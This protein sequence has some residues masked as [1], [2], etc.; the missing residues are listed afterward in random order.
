[1]PCL[2]K[3]L[4]VATAG[5]LLATL[6]AP[7]TAAP[8]RS[9]MAVYFERLR[10]M[11]PEAEVTGRFNDW[12]SVSMYRSHAGLHLGYDI[13]L[14]AGRAVPA[15]WPGR[16]NRIIP[17]TSTEYGVEVQ[18]TNGY[19]VTY[20]HITPAV[21]EGQGVSPGMTVG[22]V[23][24]D[25]VDIKVRNASGGYF[26]FGLS[27][28]VLDGGSWNASAGLLPPPPYE[29]GAYRPTVGAGPE[30]LLESYRE[31]RRREEMARAERDQI[32]ELVT[33]LS[34]FIDQESKGLPEAEAQMLSYYRAADQNRIS[35]AQ[36]EAHSLQVKSRRAKINRLI[37][38]LQERQRILAQRSAALEAATSRV[39]ALRK[40]LQS[41]GA[42]PARIA[43]IDDTAPGS[44]RPSSKVEANPDITQRAEQA[45]RRATTARER[46]Q[47]G[48][49]AQAALD[50][51]QRD[52]QRM[53]LV[54]ALWEQ[55]DRDAARSLNF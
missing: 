6:L 26:D 39:A 48:G 21:S 19:Y 24:R 47:A 17:W 44:V 54:Q 52:Y 13:A 15:G 7:A 3:A 2:R 25:H 9:D 18:L 4:Y 8:L 46:Y 50:E 28:G 10:A 12:R 1:M 49:L 43:Q 38:V 20:G 55:G 36:A 45:R 41:Q 35:E 27:Y 53:R 23:C 40:S 37:Y 11:Y 14:N 30:S 22:R 34:G 16:V 42:D 32:L 29:G 33:L 31:A 51:A 5:V